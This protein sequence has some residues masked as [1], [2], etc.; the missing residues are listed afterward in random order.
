MDAVWENTCLQLGFEYATALFQ[1][2]T[3]EAM[4]ARFVQLLRNL[5]ATPQ[6]PLSEI[7]LLSEEEKANALRNLQQQSHSREPITRA[8]MAT[9]ANN[10][11]RVALI[12]GNQTVTYQTLLEKIKLMAAWLQPATDDDQLTGLLVKRGPA[13]IYGLF[14]AL[15]SGR[16]YVPL[17]PDYPRERI[18]A[19]LEESGIKKVI[20][21]RDCDHLLPD[22]IDR[23][24]IE[25]L[26]QCGATPMEAPITTPEAP[27]YIIFTSG[28]TGKPKGV[29]IANRSLSW[30][31]DAVTRVIDFAPGK[32]ILSLTTI[33][34][35]IFV[36][37]NLVPL[38]T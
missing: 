23:I 22:G 16:A 5:I 2:K 32:T 1:R 38:L 10:P 4:A 20:T 35:D 6:T 30:F 25:D 18:N 11:D 33:S 3:V 24:Y 21:Q 26:D 9:A 17:D 29:C 8:L 13:M 28:S 12:S 7:S 36:L 27:A 34:F 31:C 37:E 14:G 19:I 15:W